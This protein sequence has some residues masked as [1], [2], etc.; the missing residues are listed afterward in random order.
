MRLPFCV[1]DKKLTF[2]TPRVLI[3]RRQYSCMKVGPAACA[4]MA[5]RG[6]RLASWLQM[7]QTTAAVARHLGLV[8]RALA[9]AD[10][11][12]HRPAAAPCAAAAAAEGDAPDGASPSVADYRFLADEP[13]LSPRDLELWQERGYM[14]LKGAAAKEDCAAVVEQMCAAMGMSATEPETWHRRGGPGDLTEAGEVRWEP[15][16]ETPIHHA[17][18]MKNTQA[19]WNIRTSPR[20]YTAFAQ[21]Y[22]TAKL[23]CMPNGVVT[24][25]PPWR[26]DRARFTHICH[27][28]HKPWFG[29]GDALPMHFDVSADQ[30]VDGGYICAGGTFDA[31]PEPG[32]PFATCR[33]RPPGCIG[34][35]MLNDRSELGGQTSVVPRLHRY[36]DQWVNSQA[37]QAEIERMR[38]PESRQHPE[39]THTLRSIDE[40]STCVVPFG[41]TLDAPSKQFQLLN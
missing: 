7:V 25:K 6:G 26:S 12:H 23:W 24:L 4:C 35:L 11:T 14:V 38:R 18:P 2:A 40:V 33:Y 21:I 5:G 41:P 32:F 10:N 36:L 28:G 9:V 19:Q 37:A 8:A 15:E 3:R 27:A 22:G 30:L 13:V 29:L 20:I 1:M 34:F 31:V 17:V 39:M 16:K